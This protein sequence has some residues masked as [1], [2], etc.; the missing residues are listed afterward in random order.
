M[1]ENKRNA[2]GAYQGPKYFSF[3]GKVLDDIRSDIENN[4]LMGE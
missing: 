1:P 3:N 4:K 2:S